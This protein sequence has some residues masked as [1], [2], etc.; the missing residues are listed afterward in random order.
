MGRSGIPSGPPSCSG[1]SS[2]RT[3]NAHNH[4]RRHPHRFVRGQPQSPT[5]S[6]RLDQLTADVYNWLTSSSDN[7]AMNRPGGRSRPLTSPPTA[8]SPFTVDPHPHMAIPT[9]RNGDGRLFSAH[10][11]S[12]PTEILDIVDNVLLIVQTDIAD[13]AMNATASA[14]Q[15]GGRSTDGADDAAMDDSD[16]QPNRSQQ[17]PSDCDRRQ[18]GRQQE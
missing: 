2:Q 10:G 6:T 5:T 18:N 15:R 11:R 3:T 7:D 16:V 12:N 9:R 14:T 13:E 17:P 8:L 4:S 1:A